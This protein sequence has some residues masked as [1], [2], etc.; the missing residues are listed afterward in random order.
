MSRKVG[1]ICYKNNFSCTPDER[2]STDLFKTKITF[3]SLQKRTRRE[4]AWRTKSRKVDKKKEY[5]LYRIVMC[6]TFFDPNMVEKKKKL[7]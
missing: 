3:H 4:T 1:K 5:Y 6:F 7:C 2:N